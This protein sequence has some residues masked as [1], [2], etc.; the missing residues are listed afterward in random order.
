MGLTVTHFIVTV[1]ACRRITCNKVWQERTNKRDDQKKRYSNIKMFYFYG[2]AYNL[3]KQ[4][5]KICSFPASK[6]GIVD[7]VKVPVILCFLL[8]LLLSFHAQKDR[9]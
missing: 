4:N 3:E 5:Y 1:S 6:S 2:V 7:L 8:I 9:V